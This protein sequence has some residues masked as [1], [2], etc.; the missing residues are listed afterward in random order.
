[1]EVLDNLMSWGSNQDFLKYSPFTTICT[2]IVMLVISRILH[3]LT[4][5][6][7]EHRYQHKNIKFIL[8]TKDVVIA[9]ICAYAILDLFRPFQTILKTVLAS[10][11]VLA[12][13]I[14]LAAQE[15]AGNFINGL[16]ILIFKPFKIGDLIKINN[17][18][19]IGTVMDI[20]IRHTVIKTYENTRIVVPNSVIDKAV[21]ENVTAVGNQKGNFLELQISYESDLTKA[22][23]IIRDEVMRHPNYMDIRT[24]EDKE[25]GV[26]PVIIRLVDFAESGLRLKTTIYSKDNAEGYAM[27]SDIRIAIKQRFDEEG[28]EIPYPHHTIIMK[29]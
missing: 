29:P 21:L 11:G 15:A 23:E 3:V 24:P 25:K 28:I 1:M 9:I 20:S 2:I 10:G 12:V 16:M 19:L 17:E 27:M 8:R 6:I 22:M 4:T 5:K 13:V 18:E 7:I 14:G 26:P